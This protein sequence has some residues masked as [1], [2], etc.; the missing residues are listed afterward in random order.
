VYSEYTYSQNVFFVN[1]PIALGLDI[2]LMEDT[3]LL[4]S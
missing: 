2:H 1:L 3:N 4:Q